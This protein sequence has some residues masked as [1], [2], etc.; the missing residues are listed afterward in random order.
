MLDSASME[1]LLIYC[2]LCLQNNHFRTI[3]NRKWSSQFMSICCDVNFLDQGKCQN[4]KSMMYYPTVLN[5]LFFFS[6]NN[7]S[8]IR[9]KPQG[10][11]GWIL[12]V[13]ALKNWLI[14]VRVQFWGFEV[15]SV[16]GD[17]HNPWGLW[18]LFINM[19]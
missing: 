12:G 9:K 14:W 8:I 11:F 19:F 15:M 3:T 13:I 6:L 5:I 1:Y 7:W 16:T 10:D 2:F 17:I 18:Q 4:Q